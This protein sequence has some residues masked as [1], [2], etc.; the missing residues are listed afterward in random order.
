MIIVDNRTIKISKGN[1]AIIEIEIKNADGSNYIIQDGDVITL[2]V[3]RVP[4]LK[5]YI[6]NNR[7]TK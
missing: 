3:A 1:N 4:A 2:C 7:T 6:I 5:D